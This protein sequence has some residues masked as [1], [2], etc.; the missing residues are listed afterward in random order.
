MALLLMG[1]VI[2][3]VGVLLD[4]PSHRFYSRDYIRPH[5][6]QQNESLM[7]ELETLGVQQQE[8]IAIF[9]LQANISD[10]SPFLASG[11]PLQYFLRPI[12][13]EWKITGQPDSTYAPSAPVK[14]LADVGVGNVGCQQYRWGAGSL[15]VT[16]SGTPVTL[17]VN[18]VALTATVYDSAAQIMRGA[19]FILASEAAYYIAS[20]KS[21][22]PSLIQA[23]EK[24]KRRD[25]VRFS[26]LLTMQQQGMSI[27]PQGSRTATNVQISAGGVPFS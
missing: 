7:L 1:D 11:Q 5:V 6:D 13:I 20:L 9:Q 10:L 21:G 2:D 3:R 12:G 15:Q 14:E 26:K 8:Q 23:L 18:F 17:R 4:D 25:R 27:V 19:G 16:P 22:K 24:Q